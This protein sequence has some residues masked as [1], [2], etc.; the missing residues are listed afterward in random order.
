[1]L[2]SS[3]L[4]MWSE[5]LISLGSL[6]LDNGLLMSW[7]SLFPQSRK[8]LVV[9]VGQEYYLCRCG[10]RG[11]LIVSVQR[12]I[13]SDDQYRCGNGCDLI[14]SSEMISLSVEFV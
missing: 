1:M 8:I 5:P 14:I 4:G 11:Y 13:G 7:S 10:I 9:R 6:I 2:G 12:V 3:L